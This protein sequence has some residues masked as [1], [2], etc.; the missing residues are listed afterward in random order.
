MRLIHLPKDIIAIFSGAAGD[1]FIEH[2]N[3]KNIF[4]VFKIWHR[5]KYSH[6]YNSR[7]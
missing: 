1:N 2:H 3:V 5:K 6:M 7:K 4:N